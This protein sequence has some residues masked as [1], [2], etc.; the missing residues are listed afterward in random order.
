L[1]C[2][3]DKLGIIPGAGGIRF[4]G[5]DD[6]G[7]LIGV[8]VAYTDTPTTICSVSDLCQVLSERLERSL[9]LPFLHWPSARAVLDFGALE[10]L[11]APRAAR[12]A[13]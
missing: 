1:L 3:F 2:S 8:S 11:A 9:G 6:Q 4:V 7:K 12:Y 10:R 5:R 13:R